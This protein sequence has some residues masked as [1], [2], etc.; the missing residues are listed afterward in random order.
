MSI[1]SHATSFPLPHRK[2][3]HRYTTSFTYIHPYSSYLH[4]SSPRGTC[5]LLFCVG[6]GPCF[7][8]RGDRPRQ[9]LPRLH[10]LAQ[11]P[12]SPRPPPQYSTSEHIVVDVSTS[13]GRNT[14]RN[15]GYFTFSAGTGTNFL[16]PDRT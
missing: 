13:C 2:K 11:P 16:Q 12:P 15:Q 7:S 9:T 10:Q 8:H 14:L 1:Y 6:A 5:C 3:T 4:F